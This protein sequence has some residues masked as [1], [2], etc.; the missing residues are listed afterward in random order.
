MTITPLI[1][2]GVILLG[3]ALWNAYNNEH[4]PY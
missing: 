2:I 4:P 3:I 1:I